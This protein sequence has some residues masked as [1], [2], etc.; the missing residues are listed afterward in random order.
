MFRRLSCGSPEIL[1]VCIGVSMVLCT[2]VLSS[3]VCV[4]WLLLFAFAHNPN[5][6]IFLYEAPHF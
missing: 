3:L 4:F 5:K 6:L 1:V 2:L